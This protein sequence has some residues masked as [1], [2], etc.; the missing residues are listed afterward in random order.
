MKRFLIF[1]LFLCFAF[2]AFA[3]EYYFYQGEALNRLVWK[4]DSL[5][6]LATAQPDWIMITN[7]YH[8]AAHSNFAFLPLQPLG[9]HNLVSFQISWSGTAGDTLFYQILASN[10][11]MD[12]LT[13][14]NIGTATA[15]IYT[16]AIL[17]NSYT[18]GSYFGNWAPTGGYGNAMVLKDASGYP[19]LP[20]Y[21]GIRVR[22]CA[23]HGFT[24]LKV[25][26]GLAKID[27]RGGN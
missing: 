24:A 20:A 25:V 21:V 16:G 11:M 7:G 3:G 12:S 6:T 27:T 10:S 5:L 15:P 26:L 1:V 2:P 9:N 18:S 13:A 19:G 4:T 22:A 8:S 14:F 23:A 17:L